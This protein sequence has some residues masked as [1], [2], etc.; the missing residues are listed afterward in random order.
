M[1][2]GAWPRPFALRRAEDV[3]GMSGTGVVAY[4]VV[5]PT[6]RCILEWAATSELTSAIRSIVVYDS[7]E[8]LMLVHGHEGKTELVWP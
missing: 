8:D 6:G 7:L 3:S 5:L 2:N 1:N 4:G